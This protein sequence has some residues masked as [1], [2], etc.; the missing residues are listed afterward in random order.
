MIQ[1]YWWKKFFFRQWFHIIFFL[2]K[3]KKDWSD[4]TLFNS[5][6][7]GDNLSGP[8]SSYSGT[9][10]TRRVSQ[11]INSVLTLQPTLLSSSRARFL[12]NPNVNDIN[13]WRIHRR[14]Y[15]N[16]DWEAGTKSSDAYVY[17]VIMYLNIYYVQALLR[18]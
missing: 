1:R 7:N 14:I 12:L 11:S 3:K 8:T 5:K 4:G 13:E 6:M 16:E 10:P 2:K 18:I 15:Y 9:T 17:H